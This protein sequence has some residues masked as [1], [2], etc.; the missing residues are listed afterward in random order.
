MNET[1]VE[2]EENDIEEAL[3][4]EL[5]DE[6]LPEDPLE[7]ETV[8]TQEESAEDQAERPHAD[9]VSEE[10]Q[11]RMLE[12]ILF[13]SAVPISPQM[14]LERL[15]EGADLN[16]LLPQLQEMYEG[17]GIELVE[18]NGQWALRTAQ[19]V[20]AALV[21]EKGVS[22]KMS[23]AALETLAIVAYHQPVTRAEIENI[24]GV[25]T[26]K[27]TLDTLMEMGWVKPGRR[28]ETPGRPLTWLTTHGFLDH[29]QLNA[30]NDLPGLQELKDSGL[31]DSRAAIDTI[32]DTR[33]LF[34]NA[35][36]DA[37]EVLNEEQQERQD[38]DAYDEQSYKD[39][40]KNQTEQIVES[41]EE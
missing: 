39:L 28:R 24:R 5:R 30:L 12:A 36:V 16:V 33:D 7:E 11:V 19:D 32:P 3:D 38:Q 27:G 14:M 15:P 6:S 26:H 13:A 40:K 21:V 23:K 1:A 9:D 17:R 34:D 20:E 22:K 37:E 31:L 25:A 10:D 35:D 8:D 4:N 41:E 18:I 29:F 2:I